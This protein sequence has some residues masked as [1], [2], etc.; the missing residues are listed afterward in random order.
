VLLLLKGITHLTRSSWLQLRVM[1]WWRLVRWGLLLLL[2]LPP[3]QTQLIY[4]CP[5]LGQG[6]TAAVLM[7][8]CFEV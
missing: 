4:E 8:V 6:F 1:C 2:L 3:P 7:R 5:A